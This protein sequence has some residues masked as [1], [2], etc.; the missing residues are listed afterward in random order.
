MLAVP[1]L[2]II[3]VAIFVV[4]WNFGNAI[5]TQLGNT[6]MPE[7]ELIERE[8]AKFAIALAPDDP[9]TFYAS[10]VVL[11]KA[12]KLEELPQIVELYEKATSLSP[13]DYRYWLVLGKLRE[14]NGDAMGGENALR[15]SLALA[16]NYSQINWAL[17]NALL[18]QNKTDEAF[19]YL[20]Q[21]AIN[22]E[23]FVPSVAALA[24]DFF[25]GD[26]PTITANVGDSPPIRVW[27]AIFLARQKRTPEALKFW[28]ELDSEDKRGKFKDQGEELF[29]RFISNKNFRAA[30][31]VRQSLL[32]P[33]AEKPE[34]GKLLNPSF[35]N[36]TYLGKSGTNFFGWQ[37]AEGTQPNI[38]INEE[39]KQDGARSLVLVFN[40]PTGKEFRDISQM[41]AVEPNTGYY[42]EFSAKTSSLRTKETVLWQITDMNEDKILASSTQIS[43]DTGDWQKIGIDF[44]TSSNT[45]AV[46]LHIVRVPCQVCAITG[47]IWF[48]SFSLQ[49]K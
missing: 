16:P 26:V 48:D 6:K 22:G 14:R 11:E 15:K 49:K 38:G 43:S 23:T 10:G 27:L 46:R 41:I 28:N 40:S 18:R 12:G 17:G 45:E 5:A 9:Q 30:L 4:K 34:I 33:D 47:K 29:N 35:E 37:I 21:A 25:E 42:V 13:N 39:A 3:G 8:L 7:E 20:K 1:A 44:Q 32:L 2:L 31:E 24:W 19:N 36:D